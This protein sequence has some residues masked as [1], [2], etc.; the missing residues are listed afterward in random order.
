LLKEPELNIIEDND[1]SLGDGD[2]GGEKPKVV[3]YFLQ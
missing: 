1:E 3:I 2:E